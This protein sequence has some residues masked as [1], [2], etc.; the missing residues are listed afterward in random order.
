LDQRYDHR[1]T[2]LSRLLEIDRNAH[3]QRGVETDLRY[4]QRYDAQCVSADTPV[5]CADLVW[6]PAGDLLPGDELVAF[7]EFSP[8]TPEGR[9]NSTDKD[10]KLVRQGRRYRK[11]TVTDNSLQRDVLLQVNT[12]AGSV[13]CNYN[14]PWLARTHG[15]N[16]GWQWV[17]AADLHAGYDVLK[18]LD[19][20]EVDRSFEGGWL[21]G[22]YDGEGSLCIQENTYGANLSIR[23][24]A[25]PTWD[26]IVSNIKSKTDTGTITTTPA[27]GNWQITHDYQIR[28]IHD[29]L[30][31]LGSVRPER[32]L[33][34]SD[35]VWI[36]RNI[37][38]AGRNSRKHVTITSIEPAGTGVIASLST[39][40]KTYI[41]GGF[42]MH[43]TKALDAAFATQQVAVQAALAAAEKSVQTALAA[44]DKATIKS[45]NS[46][47]EKFTDMER[48][49]EQRF[50]NEEIK[51]NTA[52][53]SVDKATVTASG[54]TLH[55]FEVV[56]RQVGQINT[57]SDQMA[58]V[59]AKLSGFGELMDSKFFTLRTMVE[60]QADKVALALAA[61]DK[62]VSKAEGANEKRFENDAAI[63]GQLQEQGK[64]YLTRSEAT[65]S[66]NALADKVETLSKQLAASIPRQE[67][68]TRFS[69]AADNSEARY[70][71]LSDN[72]ESRWVVMGKQIDELRQLSATQAGTKQGSS[73]TW[74]AIA[75]G[76]ALIATLIGIFVFLAARSSGTTP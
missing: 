24:A 30:K 18:P 66:Q 42:A 56:E 70:K 34:K 16:S 25:G 40:T 44:V 19:V 48:Q 59:N 21:S 64:S 28:S 2:E 23:Q 22:M 49:I 72:A 14:H 5:L 37:S 35:Q 12:T 6:R 15:H 13:R 27:K 51:L 63:R 17:R 45:E 75:G 4:Q 50:N 41:A 62:A 76:V 20:W 60:T 53:T 71:A 1:Y 73:A 54:V 65:S 68:E 3:I 67:V 57:L 7:D 31:M 58:S 26:R 8:K 39:S 33:P 55:R 29:V 46:I 43:N 74:A 61:S 32:L 52:L 11:A 69:S 9:A 47:S 36:G 38:S 10:Y